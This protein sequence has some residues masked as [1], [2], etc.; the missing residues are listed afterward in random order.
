MSVKFTKAELIASIDKHFPYEKFNP[1]Q[2]EAIAFAV[3]NIA[4]GKQHVILELPTGIGKSI[5]AT[6]IH[7]VLREI[8]SSTWRTAVVTA[9]KGLQDQYVMEDKKVFSLKGK[10]N[11]P[12]SVTAGVSYGSTDCRKNIFSGACRPA[13]QCEYV[14]TRD[15]W[16]RRAPL[17]L[18]NTAFQI[19]APEAMIGNRSEDNYTRANLT[20]I[21]ECHMIDQHLVDYASIVLVPEEMK[22][23]LDGLPE[24]ATST[25]FSA[26]VAD[27][28]EFEVGSVLDVSS[29][30]SEKIT[31]LL[32]KVY[33]IL[34]R[35]SAESLDRGLDGDRKSKL[36]SLHEDLFRAVSE[37]K[38]MF[39]IG[40]E[41]ILEEY[42]YAQRVKLV[43]IYAYQVAPVSL[44]SKCDQHVHMSATIC[45]SAEYMKTLG[46]D[47][48][49][50]VYL[51]MPNPIPVENRR[52]YVLDAL[53]VS[54][55]YDE[56]KLS[57]VV[58]SIVSKHRSASQNGIIHTVSFKLAEQLKERSAHK[59]NML[60]SNNRK[61]ILNWVNSPKGKLVLSPSIETGYDFKGDMARYQIVAKV[62]FEYLGSHYVSVN[63]QRSPKWYARRAILRIVQACGRSVRGIDDWAVTYVLDSNFRR[64]YEDNPELFPQWFKDSVVL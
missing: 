50:A 29:Q 4:A 2:K 6:T 63:L 30:L 22:R 28:S 16:T 43:P 40:G 37:I 36:E 8:Q 26:F 53:K 55:A 59:R 48:A 7:K 34:D 51:S 60:I 25:Y 44:F 46:I 38:N 3:I 35:I 61:E 33:P 58:D 54:G 10:A 32:D 45:G 42:A 24:Y 64:L 47:P 19:K 39:D 57:E 27:L 41:W 31:N 18:T 20:I 52:V 23:N 12:C 1:G 13:V 56:K 15:H 14:K 5:V 49:T 21:D 11:Y 9:T 62:P 17:R